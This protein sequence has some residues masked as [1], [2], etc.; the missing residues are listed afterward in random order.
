MVYMNLGRLK[1]DCGGTLLRMSASNHDG[2]IHLGTYCPTCKTY[3][4]PKRQVLRPV[5]PLGDREDISKIID[6]QFYESHGPKIK[7]D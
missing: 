5:I 1:C 2:K 4:D 7:N 3:R 6:Q